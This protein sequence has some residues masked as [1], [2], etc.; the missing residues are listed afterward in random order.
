ME[1]HKRIALAGLTAELY[2]TILNHCNSNIFVTDGQG[3]ILYAN[4]A[5]ERALNCTFDRLR[6]MDVYQLRAD[7]YCSHSSSADAIKSRRKAFAVYRNNLGEEI[8]TTSVPVLDPD[9]RV[10][11]VVTRSDEVG[12]ILAQQ[13]ELDRYRKLYQQILTR[14]GTPSVTLI[15][16]DPRMKE[17][18]STLHTYAQ[19][20][21]TILLTGESGTGKEVLADYIRQNSSRQDAPFLSINCAAVPNEL[22][23][24][25]LFGYEKGAFTGAKREGKPGI[26][27]LANGGTIFLDEVGELSLLAQSKLL[28]VLESGEFMRVG[29]QKLQKTDVRIIAA[30][31]RDLKAMIEA[32]QFRA[33]LYYR[34][35]VIPVDIPPLRERRL[36]I[37]ALARYFLD[38]FNHKHRQERALSPALLDS[39][40]AYSWPG[41]IR[42]LR[43]TM[44]NYVITGEVLRLAEPSAPPAV[45][46]SQMHSAAPDPNLTLKQAVEQTEKA[47]IQAALKACGGDVALAAEHLGIHRSVLYK[48]INKYQLR[49]RQEYDLG[50]YEP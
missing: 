29:G 46:V 21:V 41:N 17:I 19:S 27:D 13:K 40:V 16:E 22:I 34:L 14:S 6:K 28:R 24:S 2:D 23:E 8:A 33:D 43:N 38:L 35:C 15:A 26:F 32:R 7:G 1:Q 4:D 3:N 5:A 9:G 10:R 36:D 31:N 20:D 42:E 49:R 39:L 47:Q 18:V 44:E 37:E 25:E 45:P 11:L 50:P 30:T 48:K 12:S